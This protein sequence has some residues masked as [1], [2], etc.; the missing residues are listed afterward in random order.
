MI[1][2]CVTPSQQQ[3]YSTPPMT[4][5]I[6]ISVVI[7]TFNQAPV[8]E[9]VLEGYNDQTCPLELFE[10]IVVDSG[11]TDGTATLFSQF[12]ALFQFHGIIQENQGK[13]G[14]RNRGVAESNSDII[15]ITDADMIPGPDFIATHIKAHQSAST[16]TCFEGVTLNMTELHW[17]PQPAKVFPYIPRS[18]ADG[19]SLG[20][21]YFLTGNL[22]FPKSLFTE[23]NGFDMEFL[24]YGWEDLELGYRLQQKKVP[25]RYLKSAINYHYHVVS[26]N[27]EIKRNVKK[28]ESAQIMLRKH[29]E[30]KWFLGLNPLSVWVY[31]TTSPTG[32]L[33]RTMTRWHEGTPGWTHRFGTWFLKE[34]YYLSGLLGT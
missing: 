2:K 22:S 11:S 27:D 23:E 25:L 28:G 10:V 3:C 17:P 12:D 8:L 13:S 18:L 4:P 32:W 14:A 26:E 20:W 24:G 19:A 29:P 15:I 1:P 9:R 21:Y 30:L 6:Q 16:A 31:R 33:I 5:P 34:Y 7:G